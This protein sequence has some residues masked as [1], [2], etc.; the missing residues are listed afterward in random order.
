MLSQ[1]ILSETV[2]I[3]LLILHICSFIAYFNTKKSGYLLLAGFL[4]GLASLCRIIAVYL[5]IFYLVIFIVRKDSKKRFL[6][7]LIFISAFAVIVGAWKIHNYIEFEN[8]SF[9]SSNLDTVLFYHAANIVGNGDKGALEKAHSD[10]QKKF[11]TNEE[12]RIKLHT[13]NSKI[14]REETLKIILKNPLKFCYLSIYNMVRVTVM[15]M[16][17]L[18]MDLMNIPVGGKKELLKSVINIKHTSK[19]KK[20]LF[21]TLIQI[22]ILGYQGLIN[23]CIWLCIGYGCISLIKNYNFFYLFFIIIIFYFV[24]ASAIPF[25]TARYRVP[26]IPFLYLLAVHS[27]Y[28]FSSNR[29]NKQNDLMKQRVYNE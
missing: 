13:L 17:G 16:N 8:H 15:P 10:L 23:I 14:L 7:Y 2:F 21:N 3:L 24:L 22:I 4:I 1:L 19:D 6:H 18:A 28:Q 9:S 27:F 25:S 20:L 12:D 5:P 26:F 11:I 29:L